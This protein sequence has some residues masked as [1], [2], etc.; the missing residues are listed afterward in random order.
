MGL[1]AGAGLGADGNEKAATFAA[2]LIESVVWFVVVVVVIAAADALPADIC[3]VDRAAAVAVAAFLKSVL[4]VVVGIAA[5]VGVGVVVGISS[6]SSSIV[7][8]IIMMLLLSVVRRC[9]WYVL[10][11]KTK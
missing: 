4:C 3:V 8:V 7:I 6:S 9:E 5:D 10:S 2:V 11:S 1:G